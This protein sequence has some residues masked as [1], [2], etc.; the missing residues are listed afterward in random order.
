MAIDLPP[1]IP[2]QLA[3]VEFVTQQTGEGARYT[4]QVGNVA[5]NVFGNTLLST[6][7]LDAALA[8]AGN[9]SQAVL[10]INQ[11]YWEAGHLLVSVQY[12]VDGDKLIVGVTEGALADVIAPESIYPFFDH[13]IGDTDLTRDE[14]E[15]ARLLANLKSERAGYDLNVRY[16]MAPNQ[17]DQVTLVMESVE[18]EEHQATGLT[19]TFG[20]PGNRFVGRYFGNIEASHQFDNGTQLNIGWETAITSL[21]SDRDLNGGEDYNRYLISIDQPTPFGLYGLAYNQTRFGFVDTNGKNENTVVDISATGEQMLLR[22][23]RT[24]LS[25]R[26]VIG[27]VEDETEGATARDEPHTYASVGVTWLQR[28]GNLSRVLSRLSVKQG[29][30]GNDNT[31]AANGDSQFTILS[32]ELGA[33]V[34]LFDNF[35]LDVDLLGQ[36]VDDELPVPRQ[37]QWVLGGLSSLSAWFPGILAADEGYFGRAAFVWRGNPVGKLRPTLSAFIEYGEAGNAVTG[38]TDDLSD[39][40]LRASLQYAANTSLDLIVAEPIDDE[41]ENGDVVSEELEA[42]FFFLLRHQF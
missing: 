6:E 33:Q 2:P 3:T 1:A 12:A 19:V 10:N 40:G 37:Q 24:R 13:L 42:D 18:N 41:D 9:P 26:E 23:S 32:P 4:G 17:P 27:H 25:I 31:G 21:S 8:E 39:V 20:N 35:W 16:H 28:V 15:D 5:V 36:F 11:A 14:F 38:A 30:E 29:L 7:Q 22:N 34:S